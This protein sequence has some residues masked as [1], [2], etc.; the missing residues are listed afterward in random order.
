MYDIIEKNT[1]DPKLYEKYAG[2]FVYNGFLETYEVRGRIT[3]NKENEKFFIEYDGNEFFLGGYEGPVDDILFIP[4]Q[5]ILDNKE[6][7]D[8]I[9]V[10]ALKESNSLTKKYGITHNFCD[11]ADI[12]LFSILKIYGKKAKNINEFSIRLSNEEKKAFYILGKFL[13]CC[14]I[15]INLLNHKMFISFYQ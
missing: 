13:I 9:F 6:T 10:E 4:I 2:T 3:K 15:L 14:Q 11:N 1:I 5:Y 7:N 12:F 8:H